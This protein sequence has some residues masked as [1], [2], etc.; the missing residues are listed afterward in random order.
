MLGQP[1]K[2]NLRTNF[3]I[4]SSLLFFVFTIIIT[5]SVILGCKSFFSDNIQAKA[6]SSSF[7]TTIDENVSKTFPVRGLLSYVILN[8][9]LFSVGV[10]FLLSVLVSFLIS[11]RFIKNFEDSDKR[12]KD[13]FLVSVSHE[14]KSPLA[15]IEGYSDLMQEKAKKNGASDIVEDLNIIKNS[16]NRLKYFIENVL[17][18]ADIRAG[19]VNTKE[20]SLHIDK[21]VECES[22]NFKTLADLEK[23]KFVI[24]IVDGLLPVSADYKLLGLAISSILDNAFKFTKEGDTVTIKAMLSKD[25]SNKFVEVLI[26]DTGIGIPKESLKKIFEKFYQVKKSKFEKL[27]GSGLGLSLAKEIITLYHGDIWAESKV[28]EGTTIKFILPVFES[29]RS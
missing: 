22:S 17:S 26:S 7:V 13:D 16:T 8:K 15:V 27:R 24:D 23:K 1:D 19:K 18:L 2:M 4:Y 12:F 25:Y 28:G 21:V 10:C 5:S 6:E 11:K 14:F 20:N 9:V 3:V 29:C